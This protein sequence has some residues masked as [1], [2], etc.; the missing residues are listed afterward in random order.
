VAHD[1]GMPALDLHDHSSLLATGSMNGSVKI[2]DFSDDEE[3][4]QEPTPQVLFSLRNQ[5]DMND[6]TD[7]PSWNAVPATSYTSTSG[8][9]MP[10]PLLGDFGQRFRG[11]AETGHASIQPIT[12]LC[13]HPYRMMISMAQGNGKLNVYSTDKG[14]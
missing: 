10:S 8:G 12:G 2:W 3:L 7:Q 4:S 9:S 5:Y 1:E 13:F 6:I 11:T 14:M